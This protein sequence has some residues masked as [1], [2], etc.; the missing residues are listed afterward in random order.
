MAKQFQHH[1]QWDLFN[2]EVTLQTALKAGGFLVESVRGV[3]SLSTPFAYELT[4]WSDRSDIAPHELLATPALL[5]INANGIA[6][7]SMSGY[8]A[9]IQRM[10]ERAEARL[11]P[12]RARL[13]PWTWFLTLTKDC[14]I[15]QN[16]TC[17]QIVQ[18]LLTQHGFGG[19]LRTR[20]TNIDLYPTREYTVQYNESVHD[21]ISRLL[22]RDG[23]FYTFL[24][25]KASHQLVL[26]DSIAVSEPF[27]DAPLHHQS[28]RSSHPDDPSIWDWSISDEVRPTRFYTD[29]YNFLTPPAA[30]DAARPAKTQNTSFG[31][32]VFEYPGDY[33]TAGQGEQHVAVVRMAELLAER[34]AFRGST[35]LPTITPGRCFRVKDDPL[36]HPSS[37]RFVVTHSE[38]EAHNH[39]FI[40]FL[41]HE[42]PDPDSRPSFV[43]RFRAVRSSEEF[44]PPRKTPRPVVRG[45]QTAIVV[46]RKEDEVHVDKYSRVKVQ[47]HW[48]R[49]GTRDENSSCWI[50]VSQA[51][52]GK[53]YGWLA[54]PRVGHEV[55]VDF[56]EGDPDR[57]IITG[58]VY[59]KDNMPPISNAGAD[60]LER[61]QPKK[62]EG[63]RAR[64]MPAGQP[65][66]DSQIEQKGMPQEQPVESTHTAH[67]GRV[68][69]LSARPAAQAVQ[70]V[71]YEEAALPKSVTEN[72][73]MTTFRSDSLNKAIG[74]NEITVN[75]SGKAEGL[76]FKAQLNEVHQVGNDR[77]DSITH[78]V[79]QDIGNNRTRSVGN[80][81]KV[82]VVNDQSIS[83]GNNRKVS[84]ACNE[85]Y[86]VSMNRAKTVLISENELT[87]VTKTV[88]TGVAHVETIGLANAHIVGLARIGVVGLIEMNVV[89]LNR[90]DTIGQKLSVST[91]TSTSFSAGTDFLVEA[92][93]NAGIKA[94]AMTVIECPDITL[95]A[96]GGFIRIDS[97]G[98]T[99]SGT[100]VKINSGGSP[101]SLGGDG[102]GAGG[103]GGGGS[104][105]GGGGGSGGGGGG[106]GGASGAG[107][108]GAA[109]GSGLGSSATDAATSAAADFD[110]GQVLKDAL[111]K[112]PGLDPQIGSLLGGLA[113][114]NLPDFQQLFNTVKKY[115]PEKA[116][117]YLSEFEQTLGTIERASG[118]RLTLDDVQR[119]LPGDLG[120]KSAEGK[121]KEGR[122]RSDAKPAS[123][124]EPKKKEPTKS[125]SA[126]NPTT[127][128]PGVSTERDSKDRS[129]RGSSDRKGI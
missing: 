38:F 80:D 93:S 12:Y 103:A 52:A 66:A 79:M 54:I 112:I 44:A 27:H 116:Q 120:G 23:I 58:R 11:T 82:T 89:G 25:Q 115:L 98:V 46:G 62:P 125:N 109:S 48:D 111:G 37:E 32:E 117:A 15:F 106:G 26:H 84:V 9:G 30:L 124:A 108:S 97:G 7:R 94:G 78:D 85:T 72:L 127:V 51:W 22:E 126:S 24:H 13:V 88:Q 73:M 34:E 122:D 61:A 41:E 1:R 33:E 105:G 55:I 39:A 91:G 113:N 99:I 56:I 5:N 87:G 119:H 123:Q 43:S 128:K 19:E 21:F 67:S 101:G 121:G 70:S 16:A 42:R 114:G 18:Q 129:E 104:G 100:K 20:L 50:R 3:E 29:D 81:E 14:R 10:P 110:Y 31:A 36:G 77:V 47:F 17:L 8:F 60:A 35:N 45:P 76:F 57:P 49:Y 118:G 63:K 64:L 95:K 69:R 65:A 2:R 40:S 75:D 90:T 28:D 86:T 68:A 53:G 83:V 96:G 102:G 107:G 71:R 74:A 59:N 4:L 6:Q 92:S